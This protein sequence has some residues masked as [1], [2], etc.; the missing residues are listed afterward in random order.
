MRCWNETSEILDW[1][2][3]RGLGNDNEAF[4]HLWSHFQNRSLDQVDQAFSGVQQPVVMWTSALTEEG[5]ATRYLD[6]KRYVIQIWTNATD[7]QIA[8]LYRQGY[9]LIMSNYDAW[10]F[11]CGYGAWV[12]DGA[13]NW[14][15]PYIGW[16]KAYTN[17]PRRLIT[18][19]NLPF[20]SRRVLGGEAA[21]WSEQVRL[22]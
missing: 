6:P 14:C 22:N 9:K 8:D 18:D 5:R 2:T 19:F 10:Y 3:E 15:S 1:L 12:G 17:S 11:D 7:H 20:D 13:N 21:I 4:L 16:Q